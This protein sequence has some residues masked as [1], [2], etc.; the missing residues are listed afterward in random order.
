MGVQGDT[1]T[2]RYSESCSVTGSQKLD[3]QWSVGGRV[4]YLVLPQLLTY[5]S[6]GYTQAHL[7]V[8]SNCPSFNLPPPVADC[9]LV[10]H[11]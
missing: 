4:G 10:R 3:S 9:C 8:R 2:C 1:S 7:E 6:G 5:V 11:L